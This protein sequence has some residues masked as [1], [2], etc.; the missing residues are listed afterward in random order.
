M[1]VL[2]KQDISIIK[3]S[4]NWASRSIAKLRTYFN[5]KYGN[6]Y[7]KL[8]GKSI[9]ATDE[10]KSSY[11]YFV[12]GSVMGKSK[13]ENDYNALSSLIAVSKMY[14]NIGDYIAISIVPQLLKD[15]VFSSEDEI[16]NI[17]SEDGEKPQINDKKPDG[18]KGEEEA[19]ALIAREL[20]DLT[21]ELHKIVEPQNLDDAG[22]EEFIKFKNSL[23]TE[24]NEVW[25]T[26]ERMNIPLKRIKEMRDNVINRYSSFI[27]KF[28]G[29]NH[30]MVKTAS[31]EEITSYYLLSLGGY[32]KIITPIKEKWLEVKNFIGIGDDTVSNTRRECVDA[33]KELIGESMKFVDV[34]ETVIKTNQQVDKDKWVMILIAFNDF[35]ASYNKKIPFFAGFYSILRTK[36]N[37]DKLMRSKKQ[38]KTDRT[39]SSDYSLRDF[40][41]HTWSDLPSRS[42]NRFP[43]IKRIS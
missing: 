40:V 32:G 23:E 39:N 3:N 9:S 19:R 33:S 1:Y 43:P 31:I 36:A 42:T 22:K 16:T 7:R 34:I 8:I 38:R 18:S 17:L 41:E 15:K 28:S 13:T 30:T 37:Q 35:S 12:S 20:M 24:L 27:L 6:F 21:A 2:D 4:S 5:V 29:L 10:L 25:V 14:G 11:D 26:T